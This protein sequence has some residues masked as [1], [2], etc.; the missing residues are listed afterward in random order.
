LSYNGGAL[1]EI[2]KPT[3]A[4][5]YAYFGKGDTYYSWIHID[6]LCMLM[7]K[8]IED[9]AYSGIYNATAPKPETIESFMSTL[10][11]VKSGILPLISMPSLFIKIILGKMAAVLLDSTRAIPKKL[12]DQKHQFAYKDI[13]MAFRD[14]LSRKI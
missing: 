4:G 6:D 2:L 3:R 9:N 8:A 10:K 14:I 5:M 13:E 12:L 7:L 11:K 1:K